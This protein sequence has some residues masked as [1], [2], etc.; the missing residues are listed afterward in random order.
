MKTDSDYLR[1]A[2]A[3]ILEEYVDAGQPRYG[4]GNNKSLCDCIKL[5][6]YFYAAGGYR[7]GVKWALEHRNEV[8]CDE[9]HWIFALAQKF[10]KKEIEESV[11][12]KEKFIAL[13]K[14]YQP[15]QDD[16]ERLSAIASFATSARKAAR[17]ESSASKISTR[18]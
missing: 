15:G 10:Y 5:V 17:S 1:Q 11:K 13:L 12:D 9:E 16:I 18:A 2:L 6:C 8:C 4:R 3:A 14:P 7:V